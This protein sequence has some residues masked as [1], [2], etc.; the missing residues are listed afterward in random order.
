MRLIL[1][2]MIIPFALSAT[3]LFA[4]PPIHEFFAV[5]DSVLAHP[6]FRTDLEAFGQVKTGGLFVSFAGYA[7]TKTLL[8]AAFTPDSL[9]DPVGDV[10]PIVGYEGPRPT[11]G[12][13]ETWGYVFDRNGDGRADYLALVGGAAAFEDADF[14]PDFPVRG[15][16]LM[17]H[18]VEL[19]VK[20]CRL[21][22]NHWADDNYDGTIDAVIHVDMDPE[23]DWVYRYIGARSTK[24]DGTFDDVWA[25]RTDTSSFNDSVSFTPDGVAI[26]PIGSPSATITPQTLR[27]KSAVMTMINEAYERIGRGKFRLSR[28]TREQPE[29]E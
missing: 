23:R 16:T 3:S 20:K 22:F 26:R 28:G 21:V 9:A 1:F 27:E 19:F 10:S 2:L 6:P 18:H 25:F 4:Q 8:Y 12:K 7:K 29:F 14:P 15:R 13:V 11:L 5:A 17:L 24:F